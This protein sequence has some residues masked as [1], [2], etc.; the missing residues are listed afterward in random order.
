MVGCGMCG[1]LGSHRRSHQ[2]RSQ[3]PASALVSRSKHINDTIDFGPG[4]W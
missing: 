1:A 2:R 3:D 4:R